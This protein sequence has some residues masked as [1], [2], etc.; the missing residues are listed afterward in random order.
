MSFLDLA[1][2]EIEVLTDEDRDVL[3]TPDGSRLII[4]GEDSD[5]ESISR[6]V[7]RPSGREV[8]VL[9]G[10]PVGISA[11]GTVVLTDSQSMG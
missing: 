11:D 3:S 7:D 9:P 10:F 4:E 2:G 6:V 1:T 8:A 5:E